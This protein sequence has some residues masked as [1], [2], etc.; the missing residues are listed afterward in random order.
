MGKTPRIWIA[1]EYG[2][3]MLTF[4]ES[5]NILKNGSSIFHSSSSSGDQSSARPTLSKNSRLLLNH[6]IGGKWHL[7]MILN[8][9]S[10]MNDDVKNFPMF[11]CHQHIF[12]SDISAKNSWPIFYLIGLFVLLWSSHTSSL[13]ILAATPLS[14]TSWT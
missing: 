13:Y 10:I 4:Q 1:M 14:E 6:L 3:C 2:M 7:M 9:I 11:I 5:A 12:F 8:W